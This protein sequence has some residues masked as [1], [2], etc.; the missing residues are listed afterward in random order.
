MSGFLKDHKNKLKKPLI[1]SGAVVVAVGAWALVGGSDE[2]GRPVRCGSGTPSRVPEGVL[3]KGH[4]Y[5]GFEVTTR[6]GK[7][8][9]RVVVAASV[10]DGR[11][12]VDGL[13][14]YHG[15]LYATEGGW[16]KGDQ[17]SQSTNESVLEKPSHAVGFRYV[18]GSGQVASIALDKTN[19]VKV[20]AAPPEAD[21]KAAVQLWA[22]CA[23]K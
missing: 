15:P 19:T 11:V 2:G 8:V 12:T 10:D 23:A 20:Y 21:N 22:S 14:A 1:V 3:H 13:Q 4:P 16:L 9:A 18:D 5:T 7:R 6:D 17:S